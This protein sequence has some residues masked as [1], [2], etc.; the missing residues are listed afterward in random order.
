MDI[1]LVYASQNIMVPYCGAGK[2]MKSYDVNG[3]C[4]PCQFFMPLSVG[5]EKA[6]QAQSMS[7]Y[8]DEVPEDLWDEKCKSCV[9]K[10]VCPTCLGANY[11]ASGNMFY[12]EDNYCK[13]TKITMLARSYFKAKQ[14]EMGKLDLTDIEKAQLAQSILL[15][16]E[17]LSGA[18]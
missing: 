13:L 18:F 9:I 2:S 11:A 8:V 16:Q 10:S 15:I 17:N 3:E 4:Y 6:K 12:H 5:E 14:L 7:F 1:S